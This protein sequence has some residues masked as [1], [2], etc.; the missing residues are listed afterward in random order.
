MDYSFFQ[1]TA[2]Q[3]A[4]FL[5]VVTYVVVVVLWIARRSFPDIKIFFPTIIVAAWMLLHDS[6][7]GLQILRS[8]TLMPPPLV[9]YLFSTLG[10][11]IYF[12][13]SKWGKQVARNT[14][15]IVLVGLQIFRLPLELILA[16]LASNGNI[17][18]EMTYKGYNFD[19]I[20]GLTAILILVISRFKTLPDIV[21][22]VW[23]GVGSFCLLVIAIVAPLS[24]PVPIRVFDSGPPLVLGVFSPWNWIVSVCVFFAVVG[25]LITFRLLWTRKKGGS[26]NA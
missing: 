12:S 26:E 3:T 11:G 16:S 22:W 18:M 25:H 10:I 17:P 23:N 1:P 14:P 6:V 21:Y 2:F 7:S 4:S 24:S 8:E 20:V 9:L 15:L 13:F 19:I 5:A